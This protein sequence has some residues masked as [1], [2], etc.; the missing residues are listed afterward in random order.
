MPN[1]ITPAMQESL[2]K[3]KAIQLQIDAL[4]LQLDEIL[5]PIAKQAVNLSPSDLLL[6]LERL[7]DGFYRT[8]LRTIYNQRKLKP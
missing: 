8:E 3:A 2:A 4:N 7:P 5:A 6:V 1:P